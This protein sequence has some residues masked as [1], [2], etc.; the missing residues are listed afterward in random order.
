MHP[1]RLGALGPA[2]FDASSEKDLDATI[3]RYLLVRVEGN[4][5]FLLNLLILKSVKGRHKFAQN[6]R[7]KVYRL[8]FELLFRPGSE[9]TQVLG[10]HWPGN[11]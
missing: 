7:L 10:N 4:Y 9:I 11:L 1:S 6:G 8:G 3:N 5:L 2:K